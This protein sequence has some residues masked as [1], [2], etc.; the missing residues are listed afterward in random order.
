MAAHRIAPMA[1]LI[2]VALSACDNDRADGFDSDTAQVRAE[3]ILRPNNVPAPE[4]AAPS[5]PAVKELK[6]SSLILPRAS[7]VIWV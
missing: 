7:K 1:F 6:K 3:T 2:C 4:H 5:A